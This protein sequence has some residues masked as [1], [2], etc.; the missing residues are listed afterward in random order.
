MHIYLLDD[1]FRR[2]EVIDDFESLVWTERFQAFGDFQ[3]V[4]PPS[5]RYLNMFRI[6]PYEHVQL[7]IVNSDRV[8]LA[9]TINLKEANNKKVL[10]VTGRSMEKVLED[11]IAKLNLSSQT[12]TP[13]WAIS[14]SPLNVASVLFSTI[15]RHPFRLGIADH[16]P[17]LQIGDWLPR[18]DL[19]EHP[20]I[21]WEQN[22]DSLYSAIREVCT[23]YDLGFRLTRKHESTELYFGIYKGFDRRAGSNTPVIFDSRLNNFDLTSELYSLARFKNGVYVYAGYTVSHTD[24]ETGDVYEEYKER[25]GFMYA[26]GTTPS[27]RTGFNRYMMVFQGQI[28]DPELP[29]AQIDRSLREQARKE[30]AKHEAVS[31]IDGVVPNTSGY[32]YNQDYFLGDLVQVKNDQ[33]GVENKRVSECV[34]TMDSNGRYIYPTL[35]QISREFEEILT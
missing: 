2:N 21:E 10:E 12:N 3:L 5:D 34:I 20:H 9:E 15:C 22:P 30:L 33:G 8:M 29:V 19:P 1:L 27:T 18:G 11:R 31:L 23:T 7:S 17:R 14:G 13:I 16:I 24:L 32:I 25:G 35:S 28:E 26:R 6:S 4:L